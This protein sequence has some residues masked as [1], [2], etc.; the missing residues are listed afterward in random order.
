MQNGYIESFNG[1][2]RDECLNESY[3]VGV[4]DARNIAAAFRQDYN[5]VRPHSSLDNMTPMEFAA[6][7]DREFLPPRGENNRDGFYKNHQQQD[8]A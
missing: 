4:M 6:R 3:F 2:L 7:M 8:W 1:K 5:H